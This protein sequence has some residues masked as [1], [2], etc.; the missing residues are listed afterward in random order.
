MRPPAAVDGNAGSRF[1][2]G[3]A[4]VPGMWFT[5]ELPKAAEVSGLQ[6]D[7]AGSPMDYPDGYEVRLSADGKGWSEPVAKGRGTGPVTEI[8]FKGAPARFIRIIQTGRRPG[9]FWSIHELQVYGK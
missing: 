4:M 2:T 3:T 1:D 8:Y 5:I 7:S 6:L 9:K